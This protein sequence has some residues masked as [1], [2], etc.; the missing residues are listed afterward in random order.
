[1]SRSIRPLVKK[2]F[3]DGQIDVRGRFSKDLSKNFPR[4]KHGA[5][6]MVGCGGV[7]DP[8]KQLLSV[9]TS[10]A[11]P[12]A[13]TRNCGSHDSATLR[14][15]S[16][17][18]PVVAAVLCCT[19]PNAVDEHG[20]CGGARRHRKGEERGRDRCGLGRTCDCVGAFEAGGLPRDAGRCTGK[21][22]RPALHH[23]APDPLGPTRKRI[24]GLLV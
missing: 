17:H 23:C 1:M 8:G 7:A 11:F 19:P 4:T 3:L 14:N 5:R 24:Q 6:G 13:G 18:A 9:G 20:Q 10:R 15:H 16:R 22:S 2:N 12:R 21:P